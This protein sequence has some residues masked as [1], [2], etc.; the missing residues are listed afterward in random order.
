MLKNNLTK[1]NRQ[2]EITMYDTLLQLPL[3]QGLCK[4]D[5][6]NIIEKVKFH[7]HQLNPGECIV[8]QGETCDRLMF[9]LDGEV[10]SQTT[11]DKLGYRL[12][13]IHTT[14]FVVEPYSLFGMQTSFSADYRAHTNVSLLSIDKSF[15]LSELNRYEIFRIN[16]LNILSN[17]CQISANKLCNNFTGDIKEKF[18]SFFLLR[19]IRNQGEKKLYITMED[20]ANLIGETR[21]NVSK[22]LNDLQKKELIMLKR[23]E[24]FI[25]SLEKLTEELGY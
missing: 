9:L 11:N 19:C 10:I 4:D 2:M 1:D 23:K 18:L 21:I 15:V 22:L 7:F 14:P 13:E 20:L 6:T 25:P 24:I 8:K 12:S 5:F 17:R 16:Y 3:F